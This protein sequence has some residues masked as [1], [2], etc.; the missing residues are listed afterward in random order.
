MA[1][2]P[3]N[4]Y[5]TPLKQLFTRLFNI[6]ETTFKNFISTMTQKQCVGESG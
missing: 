3:Y 4:G 1:V 2:Y 6:A 5:K